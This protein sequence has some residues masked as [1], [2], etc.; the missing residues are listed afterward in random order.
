MSTFTSGVLF[1][2]FPEPAREPVELRIGPRQRLKASEEPV[3]ELRLAADQALFPF[4]P[5]AVAPSTAAGRVLLRHFVVPAF[6]LT[7]RSPQHIDPALERRLQGL[8]RRRGELP[9]GGHQEAHRRPPLA[10]EL[11]GLVVA[12]LQVALHFPG[13][14][15]LGLRGLEREDHRL[16]DAVE[17]LVALRVRHEVLPVP[18]DHLRERQVREALQALGRPVDEVRPQE[19][20]HVAEVIVVARM[21]RRGQKDRVLG[22]LLLAQV[23]GRARTSERPAS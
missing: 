12:V 14:R 23:L 5:F 1:D 4:F 3:D 8:A 22:L 7:L 11:A 17:D 13:E 2:E 20:E 21:R 10:V 6:E 19:V 18:D 15:D 16:R 9:E